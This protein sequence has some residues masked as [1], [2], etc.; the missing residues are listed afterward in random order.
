MSRQVRFAAVLLT[1]AAFTCGSLGALPFGLRIT[2]AEDVRGD[3]L[4]AVAEWI[5]SLFVPE[6]PAESAP[7]QP[8]SKDTGTMDPNGG[9]GGGH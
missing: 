1:L 9:S 2:P 6:R 7:K 5:S 8:Q 4:T 3:F